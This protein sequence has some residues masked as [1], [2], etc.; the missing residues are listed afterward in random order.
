MGA[1]APFVVLDASVAVKWFLTEDETG[2][3]QA[4]ALLAEHAEGRVRLVAPT[5]VV[6]ELMGVFVRRLPSTAVEDALDA[7]FDADVQLLSPSRELTQ[8]A[9][10]LVARHQL[11][12]FDSAYAALAL[13]LGCPLATA[14]RRLAKGLSGIAEVRTV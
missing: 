11:A 5:L 9:A 10:T 2:V 3:A 1:D 14:D 6:H 7:F 12:A 13:S 4:T 8:E